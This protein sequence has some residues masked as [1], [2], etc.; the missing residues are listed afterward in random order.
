M[1]TSAKLSFSMT[2]RTPLMAAAIKRIIIIGS[3]SCSKNLCTT[4]FPFAASNLFLPFS[5]KRFDTSMELSPSSEE[6]TAFI[7]SAVSTQ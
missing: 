3:A 4:D 1:I 2:A 6:F 5:S 7:T